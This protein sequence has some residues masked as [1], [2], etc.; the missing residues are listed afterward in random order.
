MVLEKDLA[1]VERAVSEVEAE[2]DA[3]TRKKK[4]PAAVDAARSLSSSGDDADA[5]MLLGR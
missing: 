5:L 4:A 2:S 1:R 3:A